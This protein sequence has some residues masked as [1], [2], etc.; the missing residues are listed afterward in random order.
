[1]KKIISIVL[2]L[3]MIFALSVTVLASS[4]TDVANDAWYAGAVL[5]ASQNE[6]VNGNG[7]ASRDSVV[8]WINSLGLDI[9][10]K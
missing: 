10:A 7:G 3:T 6:V 2:T 9:E 1:M 8:S 4:Y 5:W